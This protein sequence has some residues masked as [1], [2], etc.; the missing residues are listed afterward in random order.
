VV[1][2]SDTTSAT[3]AVG[4]KEDVRI[5]KRS[6]V[7][8]LSDVTDSTADA[9]TIAPS[10]AAFW[11]SDAKKRVLTNVFSLQVDGIRTKYTS[12]GVGL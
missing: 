12:E 2:V 5:V 7:L 4:V 11:Q 10:F 8:L 3:P 9:N 1:P 6:S